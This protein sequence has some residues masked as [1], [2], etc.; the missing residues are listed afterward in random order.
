MHPA[1]LLWMQVKLAHPGC[2]VLACTPSN[3]AADLITRR[4]LEHIDRKDI[5]R[6]NALSRNAKSL[7]DEV[8]VSTHSYQGIKVRKPHLG[9]LRIV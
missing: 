1:A 7:D 9:L 6:L 5:I 2:R 3:S 4:L 8:L